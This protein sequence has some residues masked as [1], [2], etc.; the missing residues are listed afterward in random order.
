MLHVV[1]LMF[2]LIPRDSVPC[3]YSLPCVWELSPKTLLLLGRA[4]G[5][6]EKGSLGGTGG[7]SQ[8]LLAFFWNSPKGKEFCT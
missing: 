1:V 6:E 5:N 4:S 3:F 2:P 8:Y 7:F